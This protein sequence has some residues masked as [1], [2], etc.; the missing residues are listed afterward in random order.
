MQGTPGVHGAAL[1]ADEAQATRDALEWKYGEFEVPD[2]VRLITHNLEQTAR[3]HSL[4]VVPQHFSSAAHAQRQCLT[5]RCLCLPCLRAA[6]TISVQFR[7]TRAHMQLSPTQQHGVQVYKAMRD[8]KVEMGKQMDDKRAA[9]LKEYRSKYPKEAD[10]IDL[11]EA[12][13]LP[14][15]WEK[16]LDVEF[17]EGSGDATRKHSNKVRTPP[18]LCT[19]RPRHALAPRCASPF[20][21]VLQQC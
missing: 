8:N 20:L 18:P 17:E 21:L 2:E 19:A 16:C 9:D 7:Q 14:E 6:C 3:R 10:E 11:I 5:A 12:G 1:G 13:G 15:G 4:N